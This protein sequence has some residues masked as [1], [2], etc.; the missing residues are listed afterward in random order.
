MRITYSVVEIESGAILLD[1]SNA[2][3]AIVKC[4]QL[5]NSA[6]FRAYKWAIVKE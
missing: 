4:G 5:N 3:R 2:D 1:Y 6:G